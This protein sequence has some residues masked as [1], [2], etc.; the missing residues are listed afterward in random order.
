M[1]EFSGRL[2]E[3]PRQSIRKVALVGECEEFY[4]NRC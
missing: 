1:M 3:W 4:V 2:T